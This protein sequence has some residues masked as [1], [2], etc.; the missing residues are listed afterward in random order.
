MLRKKQLKERHLRERQ[1]IDEQKRQEHL[2]KN[3]KTQLKEKQ[4]QPQIQQPKIKT[5]KTIIKNIKQ[6]NHANLYNTLKIKK[7]NKRDT[8]TRET[9]RNQNIQS[10]INVLIQRGFKFNENVTMVDV[11]NFVDDLKKKK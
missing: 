6:K 7:L 4:K 1:S 2:K 10:L 9:F 3:K 8:K 5:L 11:F